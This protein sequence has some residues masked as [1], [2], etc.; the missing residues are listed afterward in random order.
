MIQTARNRTEW[1]DYIYDQMNEYGLDYDVTFKQSDRL[2]RYA[3]VAHKIGTKTEDGGYD[4]DM[5]NIE[6]LYLEVM[7]TQLITSVLFLTTMT[8]M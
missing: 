7:D 8:M 3:D 2:D 5:E 1:I 4:L 6:W